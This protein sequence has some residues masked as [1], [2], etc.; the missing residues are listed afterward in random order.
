MEPY[1][2]YHAA[3]LLAEGENIDMNGHRAKALRKQAFELSRHKPSSYSAI[4]RMKR[5]WDKKKE[6]WLDVP[7]YQLKCEGFRATYQQLKREYYICKSL[8]GGSISE[9][10]KR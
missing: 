1:P 10:P 5:W 7:R 8:G 4:K 6:E 2:S 3:F 9:S